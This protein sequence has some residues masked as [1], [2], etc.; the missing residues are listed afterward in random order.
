M[1][2]ICSD[3]RD[4]WLAERIELIEEFV[5][6]TSA[7]APAWK[8]L[9][10]AVDAASAKVDAACEPFEAADR[11]ATAPARLEQAEL[12]L[13]TG[14]DVVQGLRPAVDGFYATLEPEQ[15]AALDRMASRRDRDD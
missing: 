12:M 6:F 10:Q 15:K 1:W 3:Q 11:P 14:L 5:T 7:Q 8:E 4:D 2:R 13:A 9:T